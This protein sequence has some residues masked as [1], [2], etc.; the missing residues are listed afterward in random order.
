MNYREYKEAEKNHVKGIHYWANKCRI[1]QKKLV[2]NKDPNAFHRHHLRDTEEQRKYNDEHYEMWG[3]EIDENGNEQFIYGKYVIFVTPEEH[4]RIHL[5]SAETRKKLSLNSA[6]YWLGKK[7]HPGTV[8][9]LKL[10][11]TTER[12]ERARKNNLGEKNPMYGKHPSDETREKMSKSISAAM[13]DEIKAIISK[14]SKKNWEDPI[15]RQNMS[16][17]LHAY[18]SVQENRD[19]MS[20][21]VKAGYTDELRQWFREKYTGEGN[22]FY[23]KHH[24]DETKQA[25]SE[26]NKGRRPPEL[27]DDAKMRIRNAQKIIVGGRSEKYKE[28][29]AFGGTMTWNEFQKYMSSLNVE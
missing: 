2:Y 10:S 22:P 1:E 5:V 6:R 21:A 26:A 3:F 18:Y 4:H 13:T 16:E 8:K 28:Y 15:Y 29:K 24:S 17:K 23:G 7:R 27:S 19:K 9:K 12:R 20:D 14:A 11:W 25:I